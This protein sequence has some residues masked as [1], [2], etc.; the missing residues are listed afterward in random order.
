MDEALRYDCDVIAFEDLTHIRERTSA[1]WGY[2]WAFRT[3]Y[4]QVE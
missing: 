2:K 3:L 4:E 1:S